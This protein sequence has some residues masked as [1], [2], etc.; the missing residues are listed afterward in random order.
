MKVPGLILGLLLPC[1]AEA[2][3]Y[4]GTKVSTLTLAGSESQSDLE[5]LPLRVGDT[6]TVENVRASIQILYD[7]G[8]YRD[9]E[10]DAVGLSDGTTSLTF[11]VRLNYFFST[12]RLD[13]E[14]LLERPL[15]SYFR[16]P[17]GERLTS[18]RV[19]RIVQDT[20]ELLRSEGYFQAVV[21]PQYMMDD[22]NRL[23][24]VTLKTTPGR[25]ATVGAVV[26]KGGELTFSQEELF[27]AFGLEPGDEFSG[28]ELERGVADIRTEF[29]DLRFLNTKVSVD[30]SY[31]QPAN[32]VDLNV[33]IQPGQFALVQPRGFEISRKK[34]SELVP[35]FEE[36][37]VDTD[38]VEEGRIA[39]TR[40]MQQEGYSDATVAAETIEVDPSLG[41]A[42]QINYTIE[43]GAKHTVVDVRITGNRHYSTD[44]ILKRIK[45]RRAQLLDSGL[46]SAE[47][48]EEDRRTIEAMYRNAGFDDVVVKTEPQDVDHNIT[49]FIRI[50]E[51]RQLP[52]GEIELV[53]NSMVKTEELLKALSI[54]PGDVYTPAAVD[55]ARAALTQHYYS[56]GYADA[57]V[58][59][60]A[61]RVSGGAVRVEFQISEGE[62]YL[63]GMI[64]VSGNT[65][66]KD[67]VIRRSSGLQEYRPLNP[68]T[69]LEAQQRLYA[70]GLFSRVEIVTLET[71]APGTRNILIQVED[72]KPILL[73]YG[74]GYHSF[75]RVRGTFEIT[76]YNLFG[77]NRSITLRTRASTR[78]R[79]VQSTYHEPRLF[80]H[81][82][83]GFASAFAEHEERPTYTAN[84]I[85][86]SLQVLKRFTL[87]KNLLISS[88]YQTV[89]IGQ[90]GVNPHEIDDPAQTGPC[91]ICQVG[92]VGTSFI[93]DRRDD[94]VN[95]KSGWFNTTTFQVANA[96]FGSELDFTS[97]F[98]QSSFYFPARSG[99]FATAFRFG[100]NHPFGRTSQFAPGQTQQ[101]P[102]TE[103][104]FAGGST[105]LRG[106]SF[107]E[108]TPRS[109][110]TLEGGNVMTIGNIEYRVPLRPLPI[111]GLDGAVF[112][113]TGSVFRRIADIHFSDFTHSA[114]FGLR[115]QTPVG[116]ARL[117][118]GFNL[119]PGTRPDGTPEAR[120]KV[121]FTLGNPF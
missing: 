95:P 33:S 36:A 104:Y 87:Q 108:A 118:F 37:A 35:I 5:K 40:H 103:R 57:R 47:L 114:G 55:A 23:A 42:I 15:S 66:T 52:I 54:K 78:E 24:A 48:L 82:L 6:L 60:E 71:G 102:P 113:D 97:T 94:P 67:K 7:T 74:V 96:I 21:T 76:H 73:T 121:F 19:E 68:G 115:Y 20:T 46:F 27:D 83:D 39:I 63:I 81:E 59:R 38:L 14:D 49:V 89:N 62:S 18:A 65:I 11:R 92:R 12:I 41:N 69:I 85:D 25:R 98:N 44:E 88:S 101:L 10:V 72:A 53:G 110:P 105:T 112:Y 106:F 58:E 56:R 116:P 99:V 3:E 28:S 8:H 2:Q 9:V 51:G 22:T 64:L 117:D 26:I 120:M 17:I 1:L 75:E 70:T 84:R 13:P 34:L 86:F 111:G 77:L 107:D 4:Y 80:N 79:F 29:T 90:A 30:R 31:N 32:S 16:L 119:R 61:E 45:S 93:L 50:E 109:D 43:P 100:W 91:Q